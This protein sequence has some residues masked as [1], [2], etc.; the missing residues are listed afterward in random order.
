MHNYEQGRII[1]LAEVELP[2]NKSS[3]YKLNIP[4]KATLEMGKD[5]LWQFAIYCD[6][7]DPEQD[8]FVEGWLRRTELSPELNRRPSQ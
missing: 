7:V 4:K 5:Y 3:I 1:Y 6:Q 8:A 2:G